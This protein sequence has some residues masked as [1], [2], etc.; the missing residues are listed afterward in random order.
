VGVNDLELT[1][2][3]DAFILRSVSD[4]TMWY[5]FEFGV[6]TGGYTPGDP[7]AVLAVNKADTA[8]T[9]EVARFPITQ[10]TMNDAAPWEVTY[11]CRVP[12][13]RVDGNTIGEVGLYATI[14]WS[15][16][17][18]EIGT[19]HLWAKAHV[20]GQAVVRDDVLLFPLKII[21]P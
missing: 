16:F 4:D 3:A 9:A 5:V 7:T 11:W 20:A 6:G 19:V 14:Y 8:L 12:R 13:D 2:A 17:P 21:Y 1:N 15:P 18:A 10:I